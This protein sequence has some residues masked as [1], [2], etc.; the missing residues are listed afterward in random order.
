MYLLLQQLY[1]IPGKMHYG[2]MH[3]MKEGKTSNVLINAPTCRSFQTAPRCKQYHTLHTLARQKEYD[4]P[5]LP[6]SRQHKT[7][8]E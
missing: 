3:E 8:Y 6:V 5:A 1:N 2:Q 7:I 4:W